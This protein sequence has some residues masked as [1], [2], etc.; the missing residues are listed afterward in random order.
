[1][2]FRFMHKNEAR[3][4]E[5]A[6]QEFPTLDPAVVEAAVKRM[7]K[8]N[9]YPESTD[10]TPEALKVGMDTQLA[11]GNLSAQPNYESFV[12]TGYIKKAMGMP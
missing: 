11:L 3:T 4:V 10:I 5:I 12:G 2:A 7:L 1:M 8:D 9:V 6:K